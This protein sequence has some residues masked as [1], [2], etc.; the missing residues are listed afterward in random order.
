MIKY[1]PSLTVP[2]SVGSVVEGINPYNFLPVLATNYVSYSG[3][4]T[5][6]GCAEVVTWHVL[7]KDVAITTAQLNALRT[8]RD[9]E[10]LLLTKNFRPV[11]PLNGR[12]IVRN[13]LL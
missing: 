11:Q 2:G 9:D 13:F 1:V 4:L 5:S 8:L 6:P 3:S 10:D 7:T 12:T